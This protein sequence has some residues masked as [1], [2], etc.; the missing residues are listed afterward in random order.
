[1][2]NSPSALLIGNHLSGAGLTR[3]VCE[4]LADRLEAK[5]WR[6]YRTSSRK[7]RIARL[8]DMV[9]TIIRMRANYD[10][11]QVAVFSGRAFLWAEASAWALRRV[12]RPYVLT[13]HGGNLPRWSRTRARRVRRLLSSAAVVTTPSRYLLEEMRP[14]R[15]DLMLLPNALDLSAYPFRMRSTIEP[16]LMWLRAFHEIYNPTM[17]VRV[18]ALVAQEFPDVWLA[19]VGL[20]KGDG[21]LQKVFQ[22]AD[23][24]AVRPRLEIPGGVQKSEVPKWLNRDDVFLNTTNVDNTPVSVIEAM[25]CGLCVV[26]TN[27]GGIPY[28]LRNGVDA[29]LVPPNDPAAMA[30]AVRR[31]FKEPGLAER[32]SEN[33]RKKAEDFDWSV[34]LPKWENLLKALREQ[35]TRR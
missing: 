6:I 16:R 14:Y 2:N 19:M 23:E 12:R 15:A 11:A 10:V 25:A 24:L 17:A 20:D 32:L 8:A 26:S 35:G 4:E 28:L 33:G 27:V 30:Q 13:L 7:N 22:L 31:L 1:M 5:G 34:V 21:S 18:L 9:F 29:L 3:G